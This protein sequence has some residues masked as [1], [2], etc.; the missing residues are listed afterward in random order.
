MGKSGRGPA[1]RPLRKIWKPHTSPPRELRKCRAYS[2]ATCPA[3]KQESFHYR[4]RGS[5]IS[6]SKKCPCYSLKISDI[7]GI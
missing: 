5:C 1:L 6:G 3:T 2:V 7:I 4:R